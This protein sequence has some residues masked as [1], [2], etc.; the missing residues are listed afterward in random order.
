MAQV[1]GQDKH[2]YLRDTRHQFSNI[3]KNPAMFAT[4]F[5]RWALDNARPHTAVIT[6]QYLAVMGLR[7]VYQ[8]PYSPDLNLCDLF[9]FT[10]LKEVDRPVQYNSNYDEVVQE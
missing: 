2:L 9:L 8:S 1:H 3:Q 6:Q 5:Y 4:C 10:R 7:L